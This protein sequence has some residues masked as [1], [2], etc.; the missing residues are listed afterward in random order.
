MFTSIFQVPGRIS[1]IAQKNGFDMECLPMP[2]QY[3]K[4]ILTLQTTHG[5]MIQKIFL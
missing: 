4:V 3:R 2:L 1:D 5:L